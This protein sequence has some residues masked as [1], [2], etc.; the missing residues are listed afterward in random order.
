MH[1]YYYVLYNVHV[2]TFS[3]RYMY[4]HEHTCEPFICKLLSK[5]V[6]VYEE[7]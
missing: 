2:Y 7:D 6:H 4:V 3:D 1:Y 5:F